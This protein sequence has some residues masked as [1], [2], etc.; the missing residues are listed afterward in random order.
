MSPKNSQ[1]E[2]STKTHCYSRSNVTWMET[3]HNNVLSTKTQLKLKIDKKKSNIDAIE[4]P[5]KQG[6]ISM[7]SQLLKENMFFINLCPKKQFE[8]N[9]IIR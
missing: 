4:G 5:C 9:P 8:G 6:V 7:N 3:V 1:P 2:T